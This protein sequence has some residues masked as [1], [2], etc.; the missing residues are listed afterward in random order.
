MFYYV[1]QDMNCI[2]CLYFCIYF[3][4]SISAKW[5]PIIGTGLIVEMVLVGFG[6]YLYSK[7]VNSREQEYPRAYEGNTN[8]GRLQRQNNHTDT[9]DRDQNEGKREEFQ[10][11]SDF[12]RCS[13]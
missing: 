5:F 9:V 12:K 7:W 11:T 10:V 8:N 1:N 2:I 3:L 6:A 13:R 4:T